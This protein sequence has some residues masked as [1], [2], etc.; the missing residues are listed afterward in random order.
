MLFSRPSKVESPLLPKNKEAFDK[1]KNVNSKMAIFFDENF[2]SD[3]RDDFT[4]YKYM[5]LIIY[6][7]ACTGDIKSTKPLSPYR[8][9]SDYDNFSKY[10]TDILYLRFLKKYHNGERVKSILNYCKHTIGHI[11]TDWQDE[12]FREIKGDKYT[13]KKGALID[14][15]DRMT[16]FVQA[17]YCEGKEEAIVEVFNN[18][19]K[20]IDEVINE[21]PYK[22]SKV[23]CKRLKLS[24][25]L[26]LI[27]GFTLS[28]NDLEKLEERQLRQTD[29]QETI[30]KIF[31]KEKVNSAT[32]WRLDPS[33]SSYVLILANKVRKKI[34]DDIKEVRDYYEIND[35]TM[36]VILS[37]AW[38]T[39]NHSD[40]KL[41]EE[42]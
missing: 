17:Q 25:Q 13:T 12:D 16:Q 42:D 30:P 33:M 5:Y 28:E 15:K 31:N 4:C 27:K 20:H 41:F 10:A 6:M 7:L 3:H 11:K 18:I 34:I 8:K 36:D 38:E 26:T 24:C 35:D 1:A 32:L 39:S 37:S 40:S 21:T 22:N 14:Y 9:F 19:S 23:L 29:N 2:W